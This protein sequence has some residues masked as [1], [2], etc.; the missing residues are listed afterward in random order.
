MPPAEAQQKSRKLDF[1]VTDL[2]RLYHDVLGMDDLS[3]KDI[4]DLRE[5]AKG[6]F[7]DLKHSLYWDRETSI[8]EYYKRFAKWFLLRKDLGILHEPMG[9]MSSK[10]RVLDMFKYCLD[11]GPL[12]LHYFAFI[13]AIELLASEEQH[14]YWV[15]RAEN[16]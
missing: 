9:M 12:T 2:Q 7:P 15:T 16:L 8:N 14:K 3:L 4:T 10:N 13:P 5:K 11:A 1:G 6:C